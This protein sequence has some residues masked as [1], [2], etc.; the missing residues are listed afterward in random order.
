MHASNLIAVHFTSHVNACLKI[1]NFPYR[2]KKSNGADVAIA[3]FAGAIM[4][5]A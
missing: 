4:L 2:E 1:D 5:K 3:L